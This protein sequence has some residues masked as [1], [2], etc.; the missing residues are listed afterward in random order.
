[1]R[2]HVSRATRAL[3]KDNTHT[4]TYRRPAFLKKR[5]STSRNLLEE[6]SRYW[7]FLFCA[8]ALFP[9]F[10]SL[11]F[12]APFSQLTLGRLG[13][14]GDAKMMRLS[15]QRQCLSKNQ[16]QTFARSPLEVAKRASERRCLCCG[17][18]VLVVLGCVLCLLVGERKSSPQACLIS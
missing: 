15:L 14:P 12:V 8:T 1:M 5:S 11:R 9:C 18:L 10:R 2:K 6:G 7:A 4:D 16:K 17:C 13:A 3:T